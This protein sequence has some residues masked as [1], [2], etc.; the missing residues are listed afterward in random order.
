M[1]IPIVDSDARLNMEQSWYLVFGSL[2]TS[3]EVNYS[4]LAESGRVTDQY[5]TPN[6]TCMHTV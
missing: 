1:R 4:I 5:S 3:Y 2:V 6:N